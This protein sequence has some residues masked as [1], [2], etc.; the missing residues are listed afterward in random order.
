VRG[1]ILRILHPQVQASKQTSENCQ[2]NV[3]ETSKSQSL[4]KIIINNKA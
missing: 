3:E 4:S 1:A 2:H